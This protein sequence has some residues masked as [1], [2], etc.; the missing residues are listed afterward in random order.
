MTTLDLAAH[1]PS[2]AITTV[3]F[4]IPPPSDLSCLKT[5]TELTSHYGLCTSLCHLAM[6]LYMSSLVTAIPSSLCPAGGQCPSPTSWVS[7][8][9]LPAQRDLADDVIMSVE[10]R[11]GEGPSQ[12]VEGQ[13]SRARRVSGYF[14][15]R[16]PPPL[17]CPA[18]IPHRV[19]V[20]H[21]E[22]QVV[23]IQ[24]QVHGVLLSPEG[25]QA[26]P[27]GCCPAKGGIGSRHLETQ[28]H[29]CTHTHTHTH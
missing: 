22:G 14:A 3:T 20:Q 5:N 29:K 28:V 9:R 16:C 13:V 18:H 26:P 6:P 27:D 12:G 7:C 21:I 1:F 19:L 10:R 25:T 2:S 11:A 17:G 4:H 15:S 24:G 23:E 8:D